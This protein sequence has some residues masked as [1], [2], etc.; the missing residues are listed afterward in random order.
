MV[1]Y[2]YYRWQHKCTRLMYLCNDKCYHTFIGCAVVVSAFSDCKGLTSL[3]LPKSLKSVGNDAFTGCE[4]L[5]SLTLPH[6][7][8]DV[9]DKAFAGCIALTSVVFRSMSR[10]G[11]IAWAV[12]NSRNRAN[13]ELTTVM[14]LRNVLSLITVLVF[15]RRDVDS[16][17]PC[18]LR[19]VFMDCP[20]EVPS[21]GYI[22]EDEWRKCQDDDDEFEYDDEF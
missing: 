7:L 19:G 1:V 3:T 13:W 20:C 14:R 8:G 6:S 4:G 11:F 5:T 17:D 10:P 22:D 15:E 18:G 12:G 2:K 16:V 9:G 21:M